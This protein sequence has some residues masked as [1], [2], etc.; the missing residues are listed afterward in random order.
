MNQMN[1]ILR[2]GDQA[3]YFPQFG[4]ATVVVMPGI[5][6]GTANFQAAKTRVCVNGDEKSALVPGCPYVS[7]PYVI[8]GVG[9]LHVHLL[10]PNQLSKT[11]STSGRKIILKG[12][13]FQA[14]FDVTAPAFW[15]TEGGPVPDPTPL[16][17]GRGQFQTTN[18]TVVFNK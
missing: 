1:Q 2:T 17:F 9:T 8:P 7:P 10:S 14:R 11:T 6:R 16:Y 5:L 18:Y 13:S 4:N 12:D 3:I 15:P